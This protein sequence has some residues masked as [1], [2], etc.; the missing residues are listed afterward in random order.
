ML[1]IC[2][3]FIGLY[4][5]NTQSSSHCQIWMKYDPVYSIKMKAWNCYPNATGILAIFSSN[6]SSDF[7]LKSHCFRFCALA[8][9]WNSMCPTEE[10]SVGTYY[11][12][13]PFQSSRSVLSAWIR[14]L[15]LLHFPLMWL[16][17]RSVREGTFIKIKPVVK[18][19]ILNAQIKY[20]LKARYLFQWMDSCLFLLM[21]HTLFIAFDPD[22]GWF[23]R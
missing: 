18:H 4:Q 3:F 7:L 9:K 6:S 23:S 5:C 8:F 22:F 13:Y 10:T 2:K 20:F 21:K 19:T 15:F 1:Q 17:R 16:L 11:V 12:Q 14:S